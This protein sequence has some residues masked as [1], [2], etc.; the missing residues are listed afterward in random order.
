MKRLL[1]LPFLVFIIACLLVMTA[2]LFV[3]S[4]SNPFVGNRTMI[5]VSRKALTQHVAQLGRMETASQV[6]ATIVQAGDL[7]GKF[8]DLLKG[9]RVFLIMAGTVTAGVDFGPITEKDVDTLS[10][11]LQINLPQAVIF[12]ATI[13][14]GKTKIYNKTQGF[15]S[16]TDKEL[17]DRKSLLE[18]GIK[19]RACDDKILDLAARN[20]QNR[21]SQL[22]M[23]LGFEKVE[24]HLPPTSC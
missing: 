1:S 13:D 15:V 9:D 6:I 11:D 21:L 18:N 17:N 2:A 7:D 19:R 16:L 20:A 24:V 4:P 22:F 10:H 3:L 14:T 8:K 5:D 23:L 12:D